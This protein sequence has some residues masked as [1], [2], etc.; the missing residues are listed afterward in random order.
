[1][2]ICNVNVQSQ[3]MHKGLAMHIKDFNKIKI[4]KYGEFTMFL[5]CGF[6]SFLYRS[7]LPR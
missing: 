5:F 7:I 1:M 2:Y 4:K 6:F 3:Q